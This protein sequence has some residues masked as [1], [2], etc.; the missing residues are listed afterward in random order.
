MG[1]LTAWGWGDCRGWGGEGIASQFCRVFFFLPE[2]E[3][4]WAEGGGVG[5]VRCGEWLTMGVAFHPSERHY[6]VASKER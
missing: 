2:G 5:V 6:D 4:H 1:E 3:G